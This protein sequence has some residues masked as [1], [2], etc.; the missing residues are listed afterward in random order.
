MHDIF[1]EAS[2]AWLFIPAKP[3]VRIWSVLMKCKIQL[4]IKTVKIV[5]IYLQ[6]KKSVK[7]CKNKYTNKTTTM[8]KKKINRAIP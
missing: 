1:S 8:K 6:K 5:T 4:R 2:I 7:K 3:D